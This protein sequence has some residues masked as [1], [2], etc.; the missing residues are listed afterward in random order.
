MPSTFSELTEQLVLS[1]CIKDAS[2]YDRIEDDVAATGGLNVWWWAGHKM[3]WKAFGEMVSKDIFVEEHLLIT[4]LEKTGRLDKIFSPSNKELCGTAYITYLSNLDAD[5][6]NV[7]DYM[8]ALKESY[9]AR[10]LNDDIIAWAT[11]ALEKGKHTSDIL[12]HID[13]E[14]NKISN[15]AT[16]TN[17]GLVSLGDALKGHLEETMKAME[18][19]ENPYIPS[20]LPFFDRFNGGYY[21]GR[22]YMFVGSTGDGKSG[23]TQNSAFRM[24]F[25]DQYEKIY[26][27]NIKV[28]IISLEMTAQEIV[29]RFV[30]MRTGLDPKRVE[31]G[32]LIKGERETYESAMEFLSKKRHNMLF[33]ENTELNVAQLRQKIR[34]M[35][36]EGCRVIIIDQLEQI[37]PPSNMSNKK[38]HE[39]YNWIGYR[40]KA[41]AAENNI[42][43]VLIHQA[44]KSPDK[45]GQKDIELNSTIV[46]Q[47][48][49][50]GMN[51][52]C[53]IRHD[54][55]GQVIKSSKFHQLKNRHG[56]TG[57][58]PIEFVAN[59]LWFMS[60]N[61]EEP[62]EIMSEEE[63]KRNQKNKELFDRLND[64]NNHSAPDFEDDY[65]E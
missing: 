22:V 37:V 27:K 59:R 16:N 57:S 48:G 41:F 24:A 10:K 13:I 11:D 40:I 58:E 49:Q 29:S 5:P 9:A 44:N 19:G 6:D 52:I 38:E 31:S 36:S 21:P 64:E 20:G 56:A 15:I 32:K 25:S 7:E 14:Q 47:G 8:G 18:S 61:T 50:K 2:A 53:A 33:N 62:V 34:K 45:L 46:N 42:P 43:I 63:R 12:A 55:E 26:G 28:G 39:I 54:R 23:L 51:S 30:Q 17:R 3:I 60:V 4:H 65:P 1:C 35:K